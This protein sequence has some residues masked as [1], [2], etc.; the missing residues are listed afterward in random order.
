MTWRKAGQEGRKESQE[1]PSLRTRGEKGLSNEMGRSEGSRVERLSSV[2][3]KLC[4][5]CL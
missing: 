2:W 4:L 1:A 5:T 3:D